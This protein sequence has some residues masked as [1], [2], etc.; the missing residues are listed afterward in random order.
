MDLAQLARQQEHVQRIQQQRGES[1]GA[2]GGQPVPAYVLVAVDATW[3][4]AKEMFNVRWP[5]PVR[6]INKQCCIHVQLCLTLHQQWISWLA[7]LLARWL[8]TMSLLAP[9]P[10]SCL[11]FPHLSP[12]MRS[13]GLMIAILMCLN[14]CD[15]GLCVCAHTY[16]SMHVQ[17]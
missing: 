17:T 16:T 7:E 8:L 11:P 6:S 9:S 13:I 5:P 15:A 2:T 3:P 14:V 12:P 4:Y 1:G 10:I